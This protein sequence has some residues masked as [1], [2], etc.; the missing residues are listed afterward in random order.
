VA[1]SILHQLTLYKPTE[2]HELSRDRYRVFESEAPFAPIQVGDMLDAWCWRHQD[3]TP[4]A[5]QRNGFGTVEPLEVVAAV[6]AV[7]HHILERA[8]DIL[9]CVL[10]F[11][12]THTFEARYG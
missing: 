6:T 1:K 5:M 11:T 7:Q 12:K 9:H 4:E 3:E 2:T 8:D 10:V